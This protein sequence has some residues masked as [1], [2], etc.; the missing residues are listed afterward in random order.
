MF[1]SK[2]NKLHVGLTQGKTMYSLV[3]ELNLKEKR[4]MQTR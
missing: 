4:K 1:T 3:I 2:L